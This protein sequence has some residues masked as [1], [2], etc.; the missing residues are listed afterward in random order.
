MNH[1]NQ[2]VTLAISAILGILALSGCANQINEQPENQPAEIPKGILIKEIPESMDIIF[3][4]IRYVLEDIACLDK[5]GVK[6]NFIHDADCTKRIYDPE[7][8]LVPSRQLYALDLETGDVIQITHTDY[9][10]VSGHVVTPHTLMV[11]AASSD[12]TNDGIIND[13][14]Q[15]DIYLLDLT[16]GEMERL[17]CG[18]GFEAINN[19]DYSHNNKKIVFSAR[20]GSF[21]DPNHIYTVDFQKNVVQITDDTTYSDFDCSWSEDGTKIVFS[22]L[23]TP[24]LENPSQIWLMDSNGKNLEKIT[25]GGSN[26]A[27]EEPHGVYPIG[28]DADPDLSPDNKKIVFSR[29]KTGRDNEPFGIF[30]LIIIDITTKEEHI[31]DSH[32]ANMVPEWKMDGILFIRQIGAVNPM[33]RKQS[34]YIYRD[35]EFEEVK[36]FPYNVFPIGAFG[37]SWIES[38]AYT[39]S[40][41]HSRGQFQI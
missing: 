4:S 41:L 37:G 14:D 34:L 36:L 9:Y 21:A 23:P 5:K 10:F 29:L 40:L 39:F 33:D 35:G 19:S 13:S 15:K 30:E 12:T 11:S 6:E 28:I 3:T 20:K 16:T 25:D 2:N 27:N 26:P 18:V 32:Y 1:K 38:V 8:G 24:W 31:L 7:I 17:T 22:R